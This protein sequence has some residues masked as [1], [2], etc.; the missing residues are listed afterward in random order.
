MNLM[1]T[2]WAVVK[3]RPE[4]K[5][6]PVRD[7]NPW[8]LCYRG[9]LSFTSLSAVQMYDFHIFLT[10]YSSL[11]GFIWNQHHDQLPVG[12]LAQLVE[13]CTGI[14]EVMG[15][16]PVSGLIFTTAQVVHIIARITFI[17]ILSTI[18]DTRLLI[19]LS[20]FGIDL[21]LPL[22]WPDIS[23][24]TLHLLLEPRFHPTLRFDLWVGQF[25]KS[26][27]SFGVSKMPARDKT[28][29]TSFSG[30]ENLQLRKWHE[31]SF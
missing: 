4:K 10:V 1:C 24:G 8:P 22:P 15:S 14:A 18:C 26:S 23:F 11:H 9:S 27:I 29:S 12:L 17:H 21:T 6:R 19:P 20:A 25:V 2:T 16:N 31:M 5:F 28:R 30:S 7:L 3:I 13:R